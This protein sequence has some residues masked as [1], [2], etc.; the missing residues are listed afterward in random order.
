VAA[1]AA[2]AA[3]CDLESTPALT[4]PGEPVNELM[5]GTP[6]QLP[7]AYALANPGRRLPL[8]VPL[9]L[10][11]G[12]ADAT[13]PLKRSRQFADAARGAGDEV[14]LEVVRGADHRAVADPRTD[15]VAP[16]ISWLRDLGWPA[17]AARPRPERPADR[18]G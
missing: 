13:V 11:H 18:V 16:T 4:R 3:V 15:A 6:E 17:G 14:A 7:E 8:G 2:L 10:V 1:V 5:G 12:D 9:L